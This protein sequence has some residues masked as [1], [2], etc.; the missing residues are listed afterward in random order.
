MATTSLSTFTSYVIPYVSNCPLPTIKRAVQDAII[1]FSNRTWIKQYDFTWNITDTDVMEELNDA[2]D[3]DMDGVYGYRPIE[4]LT[5]IVDGEVVEYKERPAIEQEFP[6]WW[7]D[8]GSGA[9]YWYIVDD[10]TIRVYPVPTDD[11]TMFLRV[12]FRPKRDAET[13]DDNIYKNWADVISEGAKFRLFTMPAKPWTN[14]DAAILA[15]ALYDKGVSRAKVVV[16]RRQLPMHD[17]KKGW[18]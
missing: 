6:E 10:D 3:L 15:K 2:V 17:F 7:D 8:T 18:I 5:M 9:T 4:V 14:P 1:D 16:R 11:F 12:A 13:F